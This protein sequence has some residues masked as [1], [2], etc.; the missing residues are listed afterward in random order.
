MNDV[1]T[2]IDL[3]EDKIK[4]Y[5]EEGYVV[6]PNLIQDNFIEEIKKEVLFIMDKIG[7]SNSKLRQTTQYLEN[8]LLDSLV[9]NVELKKLAGILMGGESSLYM[10]FTAVKSGSGGGQFHFHQDNQYTQFDKPGINFWFAL[11]K[12]S[13]NNGCLQVVPKSHLNGTFESELSGDGDHHKKIKWMPTDF[14]ALEMNPGDCVAF[15][16]LTIHGSGPNNS[17]EHRVAYAV[18]FHRDDVK[19]KWNEND[20]ILLKEYPRWKVSPVKE[21]VNSDKENLDGH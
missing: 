19:A 17:N 18:Q 20:W 10:P 11:S 6:I 21:I 13:I 5:Q 9:N 1:L 12:M 7:L 15:S 16:R 3:T 14:K 2:T 8:S 4:F